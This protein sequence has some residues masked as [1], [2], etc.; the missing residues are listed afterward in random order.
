[1]VTGEKILQALS[2]GRGDQLGA[3]FGCSQTYL[4]LHPTFQQHCYTRLNG[5]GDLPATDHEMFFQRLPE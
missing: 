4:F 5:E 1:M 3:G 2:H